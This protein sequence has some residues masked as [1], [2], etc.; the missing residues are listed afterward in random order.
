M[1]SSVACKG[2]GGLLTGD[3]SAV[4]YAGTEPELAWYSVWRPI[5]GDGASET[6]S[7]SSFSAVS[8]IVGIAVTPA[9]MYTLEVWVMS[10]PGV[11][12]VSLTTMGP[13]SIG[14]GSEMVA[15]ACGTMLS[16]DPADTGM[17]G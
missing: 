16:S 8:A 3:T 17:G 10:G 14:A 11:E 13:I 15:A 4:V 9:G 5:F 2:S 1:R 6:G 12:G 7:Y